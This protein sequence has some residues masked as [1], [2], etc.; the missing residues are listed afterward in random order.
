[1]DKIRVKKTGKSRIRQM[2]PD[3]LQFGELF[4]DHMFIC[5]Y[6]KGAWRNPAI[7]PYGKL[8]VY[9]AL[10]SLHYG[11]VIFEGMK[12]FVTPDGIKVF[13][14]EKFFERMAKS[15]AKLCIPP[16]ERD[17]FFGALSGLLKLDSKWV[18][19]KK[20]CSLY[21]RPFIFAADNFLGVRVSETYNFMIITSPVGAYYKE[22]FNPVSLTTMPEFV[23][24]VKGGL[25]D[26][27]TIANYAASLLPAQLAKKA[28]F[29][30]VLWLDGIERK[31]IEE[32][33]TMNI[34]FVI[35]GDLVTPPL[36]G[37][38]LPGVTRDTVLFL[39]KRWG[40]KFMERRISINEVI[41]AGR[42]G[43][44][45]EAFG[46]GTAAVIS[47][48]GE[49]RHK[50]DTIKIGGGKMGELSKRLYDEISGVQYGEK[51]D[52]FGW[53]SRIA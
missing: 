31:Y 10:C 24:A 20:G 48:V 39:A 50:N 30:Q 11:Q 26:A 42:A 41:S 4:S 9:P 25:G 51:P 17:L 40:L 27:K 47:P 36:E 32:V 2:K 6:E 23:R 28:G 15:C 46:T 22:G 16:P 1:M 35:N 37:T 34:F 14:P 38:I 21:I 45:K 53:M 3:K 19:A 13:R 49:I 29:T 52:R 44:I 7:V 5:K 18:P 12:A 8:D 43:Q 33:G